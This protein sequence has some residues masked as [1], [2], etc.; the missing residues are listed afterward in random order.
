MTRDL[1]SPSEAI[2][3]TIIKKYLGTYL[4][5]RCRIRRCVFTP[6][7]KSEKVETFFGTICK[8]VFSIE[9]AGLKYGGRYKAGSSI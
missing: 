4:F 3:S 1:R 9:H 6:N 5:S 8:S 7:L 2:N